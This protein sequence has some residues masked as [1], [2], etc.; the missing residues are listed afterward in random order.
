MIRTVRTGN[1]ELDYAVSGSGGKPLVILPGLS[2]HSVLLSANAVGER[3]GSGDFTVYLIDRRKNAPE[4]Y[5]VE[6]MAEDTAAALRAIGISHTYMFGA[7]QGGMIA[8]CIA[9]KHPELVCRLVLGSTLVNTNMTAKSVIDRWASLAAKGDRAALAREMPGRIYSA[10][11]LAKYGDVIAG[12]YGNITDYELKQFVI[13]AKAAAGFSAA[14]NARRIKCPVLV[15]GSRGDAVT[16]P[17]GSEELA[18]SLGCGIY[19]YDGTYGHGVY[20]EAEDY[21][22]RVL[23]F[24]TDE[25]DRKK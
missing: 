17:E 5:T 11:T 4:D 16:T 24:L 8:Q 2:L 21:P 10:E 20:D 1:A 14:E 15:I 22:A 12:A 3:Y 7:S 25:N 6:Q 19:M 9:A 18:A 23:A 13:M